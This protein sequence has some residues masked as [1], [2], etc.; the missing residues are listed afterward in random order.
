MSKVFSL[1]FFKS[2]KLYS[3]FKF[4]L[5]FFSKDDELV[6]PKGLTDFL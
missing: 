3:D 6:Q 1:I 4:M 5:L 2:T